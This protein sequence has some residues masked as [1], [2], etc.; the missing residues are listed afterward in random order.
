V[1]IQVLRLG[2]SFGSAAV[3]TANGDINITAANGVTATTGS[4]TT[5]SGGNIDVEAVAGNVNA[6]QNA[7]GFVFNTGSFPASGWHQH[8]EGGNVTITAGGNVTSFVPT[9]PS[10]SPRTRARAHSGRNRAWWP[11]RREAASMAIM[12]QPIVWLME[13][14]C[15]ARS[16]RRT[17][18][19]GPQQHQHTP[20][21]EPG[22]G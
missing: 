6:G 8:G 10:A 3:Q 16:R 9:G 21:S 15:P 14:S 19:R 13:W 22:N 2:H 17:A 7:N 4:I 1:S 18:T 11:S 20:G 5:T 12:S